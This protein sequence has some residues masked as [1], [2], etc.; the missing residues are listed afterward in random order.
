M[1]IWFITGCS[2]G[3]GK[4]IADAVLERGDCAVVTARR[5]EDVM[6]FEEEWP[7]TAMAAALNLSKPETLEPAVRQAEKRFGHIDILVNNA[8]H[9]YRAAIEEGDPAQIKQLFT[10]DF[11]SPMEL[12]RLV[13]PS[14]RG[15][16]H[17]MI[18]NVSS[19][20][21][22]RG[23]LGNGWYSAAKGALELA[24]E[25]LALETA[26][27]GIRVMLA[28]PGAMRTGFFGDRLQKSEKTISAYDSLASRY[29]PQAMPARHDQPGDPA[30]CGRILVS[31]AMREDA[32][33]R[34]L[35]GSDA[36]EAAEKTLQNRL[37]ELRRWKAASRQADYDK[38]SSRRG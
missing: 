2:S 11:Y 3:L 21:A 20:G 37:E 7:E 36:A 24:S 27:F 16:R 35:L 8:G 9:G 34:L 10:D 12:I 28:E 30:R 15:R 5:R 23:A 14:M 4:G 22:V 26:G 13:L 31:T 19:I 38:E 32:P 25:S 33:F 6:H 17:G 18:I 29:R 1:Q